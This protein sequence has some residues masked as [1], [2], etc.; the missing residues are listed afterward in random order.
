MEIMGD[1]S[2]H[3]P[4]PERWSMFRGAWETKEP[5][6]KSSDSG[7]VGEGADEPEN[8]QKEVELTKSQGGQAWGFRST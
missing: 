7:G 3:L 2:T 5:S 1:K 6:A 4:S 8:Y